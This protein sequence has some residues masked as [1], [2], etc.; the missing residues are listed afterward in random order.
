VAPL[1]F[2]II[3]GRSTGVLLSFIVDLIWFPGGGHSVHGWS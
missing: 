2:G 1:F 3:V